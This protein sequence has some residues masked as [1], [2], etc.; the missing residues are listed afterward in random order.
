MDNSKLVATFIEEI[1]NKRNFEKLDEFL[2]P[3]FKDHSLPVTLKGNK[4]GLKKWVLGTGIVFEH[5]TII[6]DQV[7]E[8]DK[9]VIRIRMI[10]RH[11][12]N[13]RD[14]APTGIKLHVFGYRHYKIQDGKI[15]E[16]WALIDGEAIERQLRDASIGCKVSH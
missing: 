5:Q 7:T 6:E 12:G 11:I 13:W 9:S 15:I 8:G 3:D 4:E 1:W 10:M 2:H 14:I 16:Q